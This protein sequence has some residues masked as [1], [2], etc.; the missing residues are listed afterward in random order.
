MT[1]MENQPQAE[2]QAKVK[3][4]R[5]LSPLWFLPLLALCLAGW[6]GYQTITQSGQRIKIHFSSAQGFV[7]GRT[8]IRYQ[9]LE[10]GI[11]RSVSLADNLKD[12]YVEAD[13]YPHATKL[14]SDKTRFWLVKPS[15]S[16][17][18]IT[19]LDALVSGNYIAIQ[20]AGADVQVSE[21]F[22]PEYTALESE[23]QDIRAANGFNLILHSHD[24]GSISVGSKIMFR[25]IP[26]GEV[27]S[28]QL[29]KDS[30]SVQ[31]NVSIKSQYSAL[32]NSDSRFWNVSG[33]GANIGF[34]GVDIQL[35]SLNALLTGAIAVD[36]PKGG[37][38]VPAGHEYQLYPD[39]K[40]AGRGIRINIAI[41]DDS[42]LTAQSPILF[43]SLKIGQITDINLSG[44]KKSLIA[45]AAIEPSFA[46]ELNSGSQFVLEEAQ[47]SLSELKNLSNLVTGN[48]LTLVPGTGQPAR[49]FTMVK[50]EQLVKSSNNYLPITLTAEQSYGLEK[51][52]KILYRGIPVGHVN[53]VFLNGDK[54]QFNAYLDKQYQKLLKSHSRFYITGS[55]DAKLSDTGISVNMPPVKQL[56]AGSIS[57]DSQGDNKNVPRQF[58]LFANQSLAQLAEFNAIGSLTIHLFASE[59]PAVSQGSP[60]LY[61][62]LPVGKISDFQLVNGGVDITARIEKRYQHLLTNDSVFWIRSGVD[63]EASLNGISVTT[64][65]LSSLLQGAIAFDKLSGIENKQG[66]QWKLYDSYKQARQYGKKITLITEQ[67]Q[68]IKTGMPIKYQGVEVGQ[69]TLVSPNFS[70]G[71]VTV[72]ARIF[73]QYSRYIMR[74][75]SQFWLVTPSVGLDGAKNLD[76]L[77]SPYL[78]V[79][80]GQSDK[81]MQRFNL[82][83]NKQHHAGITFYL[84]SR[85]KKSLKVGTPILFRD[86][87]VGQVTN[88]ELS[89][90]A[91]RVITTVEIEPNYAYLI[92]QNSVFWDVSGINVSIGL[93]GADI[94]AGTV[95]S[96]IRGGIAFST[97][98]DKPLQAA[99]KSGQ[100]FLLYAQAEPQWLEWSTAIPH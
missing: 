62:N 39:I 17:D 84:Q 72:S 65:P 45:Q 98:D 14:L 5:K 12:I 26:I 37:N 74:A 77:L 31:L 13:I 44:D 36:S 68:A 88:V 51:G 86:F 48:F 79:E 43:R 52:S 67:N 80:P 40:T 71:N 11:V 85:S 89:S 53:R 16:L 95:D 47:L 60:V 22:K 34:G 93:S 58:H 64:S 4:G 99:A 10:V 25:K 3:V 9:G 73:P 61:R 59:M 76:S 63:I 90:L 27:V 54:V 30:N 56:L 28:Y 19:G 97:P 46:D 87:E 2:A 8:T 91:D 6:L 49:N 92:R 15:A 83:Q 42:Q 35:E 20:P 41:P 23:P 18:G 69:V 70:Q 21:E 100:T 32:I 82:A 1:Q 33:I 55:I 7:E 96:I 78:Q 94:K 29:T 24:L 81:T 75:D 38:P 57:F 50:Q 66:K